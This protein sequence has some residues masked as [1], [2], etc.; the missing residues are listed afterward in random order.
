MPTAVSLDTELRFDRNQAARVGTQMGNIAQDNLNRQMRF[1]H[2]RFTEPLGRIS[3]SASEF[4]RS[5]EASNARVLAFGAS[6]GMIYTVERAF[7]SMIRV[8]IDVEKKLKDINVILNTTGKGLRQFGAELF[9]IAKDTGQTF[10]VAAEAAKEFS[11]QGLGVE[12][13]LLR[14]RDAMI[15]SRQSGMS[16][17]ESLKALTTAIN[18]FNR[19]S[20]TSTEI[21]NKMAKVDAAFAVSSEDLAQAIQRSGSVAQ[22][23][24]VSIEQLMAITTAAQQV[25]GRGGNIIGNALKSIFTR[26][27]RPQVIEQFRELGVTVEDT[28]KRLLPTMQIL[29]SL[30]TVLDRPNIAKTTRTHIEQLAA[31]LFQ[32]NQLKAILGDL[33]REYSVYDQSLKIANSATNEA[34]ERNEELNKTMAA[35]LNRTS[36]NVKQFGASLGQATFSPV[37]TNMANLLNTA[38]ESYNQTEQSESFGA[39]IGKGLIDGIGQFLTGPGVILLGKITFNLFRRFASFVAESARTITFMNKGMEQRAMLET[40]FQELLMREP[41][42]LER[43]YRGTLSEVEARKLLLNELNQEIMLRTRLAGLSSAVATNVMRS[44]LVGTT[45]IGMGQRVLTMRRAEGLIPDTTPEAIHEKMGAL[46]GGYI[47]GKI[48]KKNIPG[49]GQVT[50]NTAEQV[51]DFGFKQP[52]IL[53]PQQSLAGKRYQNQFAQKHGFNPYSLVNEGLIPNFAPVRVFHGTKSSVPFTTFRKGDIGFH[54]GTPTAANERIYMGFE[55]KHMFE[56]DKYKRVFPLNLDI[57]NPLKLRDIEWWENPNKL[58]RELLKNQVLSQSEARGLLERSRRLNYLYTMPMDAKATYSDYTPL[59][60]LLRKKGYDSIQYE[61]IYEDIG[62]TSYI[63]FYPNQLKSPF[64]KQNPKYRDI[65]LNKGLVPN[66]MRFLTARQLEAKFFENRAF[67]TRIKSFTYQNQKGEIKDYDIGQHRVRSDLNKGAPAPGGY[68]SWT[69]LDKATHSLVL[70]FK[71]PGGKEF[72]KHRFSFAN[73]KEIRADDDIYRILNKGFI[74]NFSA[75]SNAINREKIAGI[76]LSSIRIGQHKQLESP[77]NPLGVGVYNV[78]DEPG[79]LVQGIQRVASEGRSPQLAGTEFGSKG[80]IPSFADLPQGIFSS[81]KIDVAGLNQSLNDLKSQIKSGALGAKDLNKA[82]SNLTD[83]YGLSAQ[84]EKEAVRRI[85]LKLRNTLTYFEGSAR[86]AAKRSSFMSTQLPLIIRGYGGG[87]LSGGQTATELFPSPS[88]LQLRQEQESAAQLRQQDINLI[89][90][91][92]QSG[93]ARFGGFPVFSTPVANRAAGMLA[94]TTRSANY[95][96]F[97]NDLVRRVEQRESEIFKHRTLAKRTGFLGQPTRAYRE[98]AR[99]IM[100][101][102]QQNVRELESR[103]SNRMFMASIAA[104]MIGE[105]VRNLIGERT[106]EQR[107]AGTAISTGAHAVG[108]GA[109]VGMLAPATGPAGIAAGAGIG[110]LLGIPKIIDAWKSELPDLQRE[111]EKVSSQTTKTGDSLST[112]LRVQNQLSDVYSGQTTLSNRRLQQIEQQQEQRLSVLNAT[113]RARVETALKSGGI[114]S[115]TDVIGE[116]TAKGIQREGILNFLNQAEKE[117]L[118]GPSGGLFST[119]GSFINKMYLDP[120]NY[121]RANPAQILG[122]IRAEQQ[123]TRQL[124]MQTG[125][126]STRDFLLGMHGEDQGKSITL[127]NYLNKNRGTADQLFQTGKTPEEFINVFETLLTKINL[128]KDEINYTIDAIRKMGESVGSV[129][130]FIKSLAQAFN[131]KEVAAIVKFN[132]DYKAANQQAVKN[133][134]RFGTILTGTILSLEAFSAQV[135]LSTD[136]MMER[137]KGA[138]ERR[139]IR[140]EGFI[141][142]QKELVGPR[143]GATL[144]HTLRLANIQ[145]QHQEKTLAA[146]GKL[147]TDFVQNFGK[148]AAKLLQGAVTQ[149]IG[150]KTPVGDPQGLYATSLEF[151]NTYSEQLVKI[152]QLFEQGD[153]N[154][155]VNAMTDYLNKMRETNETLIE[156]GALGGRARREHTFLNDQIKKGAGEIIKYVNAQKL[157]NEAQKQQTEIAKVQYQETLKNIRQQKQITYGGGLEGLLGGDYLT[158]LFV[159]RGLT[160]RGAASGN[161]F[162]ELH[163]MQMV[164]GVLK[165]F[166]VQLSD[167]FRAN[168]VDK[169]SQ[170][171]ETRIPPTL[172]EGQLELGTASELAEKIISAYAPTEKEEVA[173]QQELQKLLNKQ[174]NSS[175]GLSIMFRSVKDDGHL[176]VKIGNLKDL[177]DKLNIKDFNDTVKELKELLRPKSTKEGPVEKLDSAKRGITSARPSTSSQ[178]QFPL[179]SEGTSTSPQSKGVQWLPETSKTQSKI[180]PSF[181][182]FESGIGMGGIG[183]IGLGVD[184]NSYSKEVQRL[185]ER[186]HLGLSFSPINEAFTNQTSGLKPMDTNQFNSFIQ[187]IRAGEMSETDYDTLFNNLDKITSSAQK[188]SDNL[189]KQ[190]QERDRL[191]QQARQKMDATETFAPSTPESIE[192]YKV[193]FPFIN[194]LNRF[195]TNLPRALNTPIRIERD[196]HDTV[197]Q[198][199]RSLSDFV[200]EINATKEALDIMAGQTLPKLQNTALSIGNIAEKVMAPAPE[201]TYFEKLQAAGA[202]M[203]KGLQEGIIA[204]FAGL[205]QTGKGFGDVLNSFTKG[206]PTIAMPQRADP[207]AVSALVQNVKEKTNIVGDILKEGIQTNVITPFRDLWQGIKSLKPEQKSEPLDRETAKL[208]IQT[209]VRPEVI[210]PIIG[211]LPAKLPSRDFGPTERKL[212]SFLQGVFGPD[213]KLPSFTQGIFGPNASAPSKFMPMNWARTFSVKDSTS[214][215]EDFKNQQWLRTFSV[216][217]QAENR[218]ED[219]Q[220]QQWIRTFSAL[221]PTELARRRDE[222]FQSQAYIRNFWLQ[223]PTPIKISE[224]EDKRTRALGS[225]YADDSGI[226]QMGQLRLLDYQKEYLETEAEIYAITQATTKEKKNFS[227]ILADLKTSQF[228]RDLHQAKAEVEALKDS[229]TGFAEEIADTTTEIGILNSRLGYTHETFKDIGKI[230]S[231]TLTYGLKEADRDLKLLAKDTAENLKTGLADALKSFAKGTDAGEAFRTFGYNFF[232]RIFERTIDMGTN[233][234]LGSLFGNK[235]GGVL[236]KLLTGSTGGLVE[237][238]SGIK[239]DVPALLQEG[240]YV[241]NKDAV[242]KIGK[243]RLS[244][245]NRG[246]ANYKSIY[247]QRPEDFNTTLTTL[248]S[249]RGVQIALRNMYV[250]DDPRRPT[251]GEFNIDERLSA[252][253]L[254]DENNPQNRL[255]MQREQALENYLKDRAAYDEM[256]RKARDQWEKQKQQ[257]LISAGINAG[258]LIGGAYLTQTGGATSIEQS[259]G[260]EPGG[261]SSQAEANAWYNQGLRNRGGIILPSNRYFGSPSGDNVPVLL[262][263]GEYVIRK[264]IVNQYGQDFFNKLNSGQI[265]GYA[266]G[267][268]VNN[269]IT[270]PLITG[271][272]NLENLLSQLIIIN[273]DIKVSLDTLPR[274]ISQPRVTPQNAG[275]DSAT[276]NN[277][278]NISVNVD[279][280]D[281]VSTTT[282]VAPNEGRT[283]QQSNEHQKANMVQLG[284]MIKARVVEVIVNE[285]RNG[286]LL[287]NAR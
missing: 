211:Q 166:N 273:R 38:L 23:A 142:R 257:R 101:E 53:P 102:E 9:N 227:Q 106:R 206:W 94:E 181:D 176:R 245:I 260:L 49:I 99:T 57:K 285:K 117:R 266:A 144:D 155:G 190:I 201:P 63:A 75:L 36:Q 223:K 186:V 139:V 128:P 232:E 28:N 146:T 133:S 234:F 40:R 164:A 64:G 153:V 8:A 222:D 116:I 24:G 89:N 264:D 185:M 79:G 85:N 103:F 41:A 231:S 12:E 197:D 217:S 161:L 253:A 141:E 276:N 132:E 62:S 22:D 179:T 55:K 182:I 136:I 88:I 149:V 239:D 129:P 15:L 118:E 67:G 173:R 13:T 165:D 11:R 27:Q 145:F 127:L 154:A 59:R 243:E 34:I 93:P 278:I 81:P 65:G 47:P 213:A 254:L 91:Q 26:I 18:S 148:D 286:G 122:E 35:L 43:I 112:F 3:R 73:F 199:L 97:I 71:R 58:L 84:T 209:L 156:S 130:D 277:Y 246:A 256:V 147:R 212:P 69:E 244:A 174:I 170:F 104:P 123:S 180:K 248:P 96:N 66:F 115:A 105:S 208:L 143:T 86:E 83:T 198:S 195:S 46:A 229:G 204:P 21:I 70:Y 210:M 137:F 240:E 183:S 194:T 33:N 228:R 237:G 150:T 252:F 37:L 187:K 25:T 44:G 111:L 274:Q 168:F 263:G 177:E 68:G 135:K 45:T 216:K 60:R 175:E 284:E 131:P 157:N 50:Y 72:M 205:Y 158:D 29:Q 220:K 54:V 163:G 247:T 192:P 282:N 119:M 32:I 272:D 172:R 19:T 281:R 203:G 280:Q 56:A 39:K 226:S 287:A 189:L 61:N 265:R 251:K 193:S 262:T 134:M 151:L 121:H 202:G 215:L 241:I 159:G 233:Y 76:D 90:Q 140:G 236:G 87:S 162:T 4:N 169:L 218:D 235:G 259:R 219:F 261:F 171:L 279:K 16:V 113:Q 124:E 207:A 167:S 82:I 255:R 188:A 120:K 77:L 126:K 214:M 80:I 271:D 221:T 30:A 109:M 114:K 224:E 110:L 138:T 258:M 178:R 17:T 270:T 14:T 74:P 196:F 92:R 31:G 2:R 238:G 7:S 52:A 242:E 20:I 275:R 78:K 42:I 6:A 249:G 152:N 200:Q 250:Y 160:E 108:I 191:A 267:G 1:D 95:H 48:A 230:I 125:V 268:P 5:L 184:R 283:T 269:N 10:D 107:I 51:V 225:F 100:P 98:L